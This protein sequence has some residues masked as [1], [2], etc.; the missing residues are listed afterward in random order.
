M[1]TWPCPA[2][3]STYWI[4]NL[5]L[6]HGDQCCCIKPMILCPKFVK[7]LATAVSLFLVSQTV[8]TPG[9][10]AESNWVSE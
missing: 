4:T 3:K 2:R 10:K 5:F 8:F 6:I 9:L 7:R 1:I